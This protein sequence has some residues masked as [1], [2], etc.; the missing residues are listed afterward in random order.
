MQLMKTAG[1]TSRFGADANYHVRQ[2]S[3]LRHLELICAEQSLVQN[4]RRFE[5]RRLALA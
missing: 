5:R 3:S 2:P 4:Y 1:A